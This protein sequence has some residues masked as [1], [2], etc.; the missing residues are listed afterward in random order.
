MKTV[1]SPLLARHVLL[2]ALLVSVL[3][4]SV[5]VSAQEVDDGFG[6][7]T[8]TLTQG[9]FFFVNLGLYT[10]YLLEDAGPLDLAQVQK[11]SG[12]TAIKTPFIDFGSIKSGIWLRARLQNGTNADDIWRL[13]LRR[14]TVE[15]VS[16]YTHRSGRT[17]RILQYTSHS[18]YGDRPI[19]HRNLAV[20][21]EVGR[22]EIVD[23]YIR[24][25]GY[26]DT[27]LPVKIASLD[28]HARAY[29]IDDSW[30]SGFYGA[31]SIVLILT[32][33]TSPIVGWRLASAFGFYMVLAT[34]WVY[35]TQGFFFARLFPEQQLLTLR[36]HDTFPPLF[37]ASFLALGRL[38]F[39]LDSRFVRF[40]QLRTWLIPLLVL[41]ALFLLLPG[42][43]DLVRTLVY[44]VAFLGFCVQITTGVLARRQR[45]MGAIPFLCGIALVALGLGG[46]LV[47]NY[48]APPGTVDFNGDISYLR[49]LILAEATA[50]AAAIVSRVM[51]LKRER[52]SALRTELEL[53]QEKLALNEALAVSEERYA[54]I[55][56]VSEERRAELSSISHDLTQPLSALRIA[57]ARI[58]GKDEAATQELNEAFDYLERVAR[59]QLEDRGESQ[60]GQKHGETETFPISTILDNVYVMFRSEAESKGLKFR[61]HSPSN[62]VDSDPLRLMRMVSNLVS[63]A[64]NHTGAGGVLLGARQRGA[65]CVVEI[66]DTGPGMSEEELKRNMAPHAKGQSS[67]GS[68]LGL[69]IVAEMS[70]KLGHDF[71][72]TSVPGRG[73]VARIYV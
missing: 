61:L 29:A 6:P 62:M 53:V 64:I 3:V 31:M 40:D 52:D 42:L 38:L 36:L 58:G 41:S 63:N 25:V 47:Q 1:I 30:T 9:D 16:V 43:P 71:E 60:D 15:Q 7:D 28:T 27:K 65:R 12:W 4:L 19:D 8:V 44:L 70:E 18:A 51:G 33:L 35:S 24:Y 37:V 17:E 57:L 34:A 39:P 72:I 67:N 26:E 73:T 68:G 5:R 2:W 66:W 50:F 20:D 59:R 22:D 46:I 56:K 69:S 54:H 55:R 10:E 45:M 21:I 49:N 32:V 48:L 13:D 23:L 14:Q 11:T